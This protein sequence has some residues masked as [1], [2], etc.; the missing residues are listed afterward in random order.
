MESNIQKNKNYSLGS[1]I[2]PSIVKKNKKVLIKI[3]FMVGPEDDT[4]V[5]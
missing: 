4:K 2:N 1:S 5:T 3:P